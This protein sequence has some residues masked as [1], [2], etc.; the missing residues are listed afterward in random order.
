MIINQGL[1]GALSN[2]WPSNI[3]ALGSYDEWLLLYD[4]A[5]QHANVDDFID[6]F[7]YKPLVS[8][9]LPTYNS[10]LDYLVQAIE[11]V[12]GQSYSNWQLC[13]ADDASTVK[14]LKHYLNGLEKDEKISVTFRHANG[15]ISAATNSAINLAAGE[16]VCFLD[17][18][19]KLHPHALA[20][21]VAYL[22]KHKELDIL[23]SDEDKI[24]EYGNRREPFFKPEW[25]WD[26]LLSQNYTC[27]LSVYRKTLLDKLNGLR[28]GTEGAQDYD[29]IIRATEQTEKIKHIP[30]VLYHWR[31]VKGST[32]LGAQEK[33][34]AHQKAVEVLNEAVARR[35]L[36]AEVL[37]T[38]L[39]AYHRLRYDVPTPVPS[40]SVIIPT[41]DRID[42]LATCLNGLLEKTSYE[43]FEILV[44]DNNSFEA[45]TLEYFKVM[46]KNDKVSILKFPGEF[47]FSAINNFAVSKAKGE[48][49]VLLNNDIEV[50]SEGWLRELVSHA[51]RPGVGAVGCRLYYPDDHVQHDG[52]VVGMGGVA[53][54]AHP[55]L[56]REYSGDFGRSKIIRNCSA[57]TA[58]ALAIRKSIYNEVGG[59][60]A[61][62]LA[63]A[64]NDVDFCLR[65]KEAG[66]RNVY[67]P[68]S[69][70]YH[71]ESVSR[72]PDTDPVKAKR[73][74]REAN[75]M[76]N[77]W[78]LFI[79]N[80]PSYN[81]NLSLMEG[82]KIDL[83]RGKI[84]PW[85]RN[86]E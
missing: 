26:L 27:H 75:Y 45:R 72:G 55:R 42:L 86:G 31:A 14:S 20:T 76:K 82:Y 13:I 70:L 49:L 84:W 83:N 53:G 35:N 1:G 38:G 10:N 36:S 79:D 3:T 32:A 64:F 4:G 30:H 7:D 65:V 60:D 9:I 48:V 51:I 37:E 52:I 54:Y 71:H 19:D 2:F 43:N 85:N 34:Y 5:D 23:Y 22:N 6:N 57:V 33:D 21:V 66:Y 47:N 68:Y 59:L 41:K 18:D 11:S 78:K 74:E 63:V 29:L 15:H 40:V 16:F 61:E 28:E 24:D 67:S 39:G 56:K 73:F 12:R 8:I 77:K 44:V 69:E 46:E 50:I 80:D 62:N 58:A 17:H 81:S 25:S